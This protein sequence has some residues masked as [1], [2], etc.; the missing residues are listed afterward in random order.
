MNQCDTR[1]ALSDG[2]HI[3]VYEIRQQSGGDRLS[4]YYKAWNHHLNQP[5]WLREYF[6]VGLARRRE[7]GLILDY[8]PGACERYQNGLSEFLYEAE[9][10]AEIEHEAIVNVLNA[11]EFNHTGYQIMRF[12]SGPSLSTVIDSIRSDHHGARSRLLFETLLDGLK[13]VHEH[14]LVHGMIGPE[15]ILL[16]ESGQAVL[17][18]FPAGLLQFAK[19]EGELS[20]I[21]PAQYASPEQYQADHV[22]APSDDLYALGATLFHCLAGLAPIP[23]S[24]RMEYLDRDDEDPLALAISGLTVTGDAAWIQAVQWMLQP[25]ATD[26]PQRAAQVKQYLTAHSERPESGEHSNG[27]AKSR[28]SWLRVREIDWRLAS[29][30]VILFVLVIGIWAVR[31][32]RSTDIMRRNPVVRDAAKSES[33]NSALNVDD[34]SERYGETALVVPVETTELTN[35]AGI[36]EVSEDPSE[37]STD[38]EPNL[39]VTEA[40]SKPFLTSDTW[41]SERRQ[42]TVAAMLAAAEINLNAYNLTTPKDDNA[43]S[44]YQA[45]LDLDPGNQEAQFGMD[46][47]LDRYIRLI[48]SAL[49]RG[50][51]QNARVYLH[52]AER[53]AKAWSPGLNSARSRL[54]TAQRNA[55]KLRK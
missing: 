43:Y 30:V 24:E 38:T 54:K 18:N 52:R 16:R 48:D 25:E 47:I 31:P 27:I 35:F 5:V 55:S 7:D 17:V 23:P 28:F 29:S 21:L 2:A 14:G 9:R 1:S 20:Q 8:V 22:P 34:E 13:L 12:E 15:N 26:R 42:S 32:F 37:Q 53:F 51:L 50:Q 33:P 3:G 46:R 4:L 41:D 45:V 6:P 40:R 49:R 36:E 19:D 10:L 39:A 44:N 11:L